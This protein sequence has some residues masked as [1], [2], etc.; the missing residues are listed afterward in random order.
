MTYQEYCRLIR[1]NYTPAHPG[2][3]KLKEEFFT[4]E[5]VQAVRAGSPAALSKACREVHPDVFAF[6]MLRPEFC[7]ALLDEVAHFETWCS[8]SRLGVV[9]PNTMNNYGAVLDSF[10]FSP[11]LDRLMAEYVS[12]LA[13]RYYPEVGGNSLDSHHGFVV[14]YQPGKDVALDFH[15][16]ESDVTL[17]VCL[18]KQF[19]GGE[20]F[21]RGARCGLCQHTPPL[22][23][24]DFAFA[25][26][27]G[28]AVLHRGKHRHGANPILSGHRFNLILWCNSSRYARARDATRCPAWCGWAGPDKGL[29][30][31]TVAAS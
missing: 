4:P 28:R 18:G 5:L 10:G 2:L 24:E 3:F 20:L 26:A 1:D 6:D 15:V 21:F 19:T 23:G 27:P 30:D 7:A 13:A 17:N 22:P 29:A 31:Q 12:P 25:H 9:R 11:M 8:R 14:E 16:D